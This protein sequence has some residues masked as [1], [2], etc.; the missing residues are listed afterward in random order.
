MAPKGGNAKKESGRAKKAEN[1]AKKANA[2]EADKERKEADQ[3]SQGSKANKKQDDKEERRRAE[4]ARKAENARLLA[5]EETSAPAKVKAAPKAGAAKKATPK[6]DAR[7]AGPGAIAAGGGLGAVSVAAEVEAPKEPESFSATGI[8]NAIDL[9]EVVNAKMD[10]ASVGTRA[11]DIERHPEVRCATNFSPETDVICPIAEEHPGLRLNQYHDLLF[12]QFQKS[13][14]NPSLVMARN[15]SISIPGSPGSPTSPPS[16]TMSSPSSP[17]RTNTLVMTRLPP[18][19]FEP[20]IQDAF[21]SHFES[22]GPLYSWAPIKGF[23]RVIMT[24]FSET[25]AEMAKESNDGLVFGDLHREPEFV[26]RVYRADPTPIDS[27]ETREHNYYLKPPANEKNF[28]I[29][30]PGS[31]PVGWEQLREDPPNATPLAGDLIAALRKLE[32]QEESARRGPGIEV[33]VE[34]QDGVGISVCVEDCDAVAL[35]DGDVDMDDEDWAYGELAPSRMR[36]RPPPTSMPPIAV[37]A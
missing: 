11:A 26:L 15:L 33:L 32:V 1:E 9:L 20:L 12:K 6:K 3:W 19:F 2:A 14:E 35:I 8:D 16:L 4:L 13:P 21:R 34:P 25:D 5:E 7:P 28:L 10:K 22:Y 37:S 24:Y 29:S 17:R 30:P 31:P 18:H 27:D 23:A 36:F